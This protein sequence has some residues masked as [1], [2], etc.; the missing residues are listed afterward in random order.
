MAPKIARPMAAAKPK[1][2]TDVEVASSCGDFV[3][4]DDFWERLGKSIYGE[5]SIVDITCFN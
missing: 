1:K 3:F 5:A 4:E 2:G